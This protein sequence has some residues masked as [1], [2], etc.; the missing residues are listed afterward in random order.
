MRE[1]V[2]RASTKKDRLE[3]TGTNNVLTERKVKL[4]A[5]NM[6]NLL[7]LSWLRLMFDEDGAALNFDLL[8]LFL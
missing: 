7:K 3:G 8:F 2:R 1:K 6:S 5:L 4:M